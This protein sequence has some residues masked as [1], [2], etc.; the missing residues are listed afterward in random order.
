MSLLR[1]SCGMPFDPGASVGRG[2]IPAVAIS[3]LGVGI[4]PAHG[5]ATATE[6]NSDA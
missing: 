4:G 5:I 1:S 2:D 6:M 3:L